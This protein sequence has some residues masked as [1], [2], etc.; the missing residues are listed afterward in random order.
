MAKK[1]IQNAI[2]PSTRGAL[3]RALG[4]SESKKIPYAQIATAA[5]KGGRLGRM[6]RLAMTL[7]KF[8]K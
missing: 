6:A 4:V 7:A 2:K 8:K 3:H 1:W 5:Q